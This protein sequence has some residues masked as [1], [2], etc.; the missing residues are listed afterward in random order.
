MGEQRKLRNFPSRPMADPDANSAHSVS[1][2]F[3]VAICVVCRSCSG[4]SPANLFSPLTTARA[5]FALDVGLWLRRDRLDM[6]LPLHGVG[7][8]IR[9]GF[10]LSVCSDSSSHLFDGGGW[11]RG[12]ENDEA[13]RSGIVGAFSR[14]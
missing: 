2:A 9:Q 5:S 7:A 6:F 8:A 1:C 3:Q 14:V 4:A 13:D 11:A 10:H 12:D